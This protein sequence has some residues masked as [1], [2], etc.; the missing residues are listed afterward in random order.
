MSFRLERSETEKFSRGLKGR[1]LGFAI[2][3]GQTVCFFGRKDSLASAYVFVYRRK[4][5]D[6]SEASAA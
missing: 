1:S 6:D 4:H 3:S 2:A 5:R